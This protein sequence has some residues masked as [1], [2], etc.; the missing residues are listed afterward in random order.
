M[1]ALGAAL[2]FAA[3][4]V[5]SAATQKGTDGSDHMRGTDQAD[6]INSG[7]GD[8]YIVG[9][10]GDDVL[11]GGA[12]SDSIDGGTGND[13]VYGASAEY[14]DTGLGRYVD[15][16]GQELLIGGDGNDLIQANACVAKGCGH[17]R[18]IAL[19]STLEGG[20]GDDVAIGGD[21]ADL[22]TGGD[23]NDSLTGL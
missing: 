6:N 8:D 9:L 13:K 20:A 3:V 5:V 11:Q 14:G 17:D 18:N 21:A 2:S 22:I 16:P 7:K 19:A 12:D 15:N 4:A 23:G 10:G 1:L